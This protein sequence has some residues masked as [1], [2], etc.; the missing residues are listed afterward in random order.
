MRKHS[1]QCYVVCQVLDTLHAVQKEVPITSSS[2]PEQEKCKKHHVK[3]SVYCE[4]CKIC[5]CHECALW[6]EEHRGHTFKPLNVIYQKHVE[7]LQGEVRKF[8][9]A[10]AF[11]NR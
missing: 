1:K 7:I 4:T 2:E 6:E 5:I 10:L 3:A 8:A 9:L 11:C